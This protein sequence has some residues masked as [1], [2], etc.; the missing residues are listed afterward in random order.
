MSR[1]RVW[2]LPTRLSHWLLAAA[3]VGA[4]VTGEIGG[5]LIEWHARAGL[6]TIGLVSFRIVWGFLGSPTARFANFVRGPAAIRSYLRGEWRGV[7]HNPLGAL[8]VLAL[9]ALAATQVAT[10]LFAN[11]DIAFQGPLA[12]LVSKEWSDH[13]RAIHVQLFYGLAAVVALHVGAIVFYLRVKRQNLIKPMLT[14][15]QQS[16]PQ[17]PAPVTAPVPASARPRHGRAALAFLVA[18]AVASTTVAAAS[19][20]FLPVPAPLEAPPPAAAAAW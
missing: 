16:D 4:A 19:G 10:G 8:A 7:G 13:W 3:V 17:I 12:D 15:W 20:A 18:S 9:L 2:D 5:A 1:L 14:G 6:L 11:D